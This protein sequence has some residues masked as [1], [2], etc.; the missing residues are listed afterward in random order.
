MLQM[1]RA[2]GTQPAVLRSYE[3]AEQLADRK[4]E[5]A[6]AMNF[7]AQDNREPTEEQEA[8][9]ELLRTNI[10]GVHVCIASI[11]KDAGLSGLAPALRMPVLA[12]A[13]MTNSIVLHAVSECGV[14][15]TVLHVRRAENSRGASWYSFIR[16]RAGDG[17]MRWG[18]GARRLSCRGWCAPPLFCGAV[19]AAVDRA[20]R[21][22]AFEYWVHPPAWKFD[23][24]DDEWP[25]LET[26]KKSNFVCLEQVHV[27]W[28]N[29]A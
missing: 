8:R 5:Q 3:R 13:V 15:G 27:D 9:A 2:E 1:L 28:H 16:Y 22:R 29:M 20:P 12:S 23:A 11:A 18:H 21:L 6:S 26:V 17:S 24:A 7:A 25:R 4:A 14:K 10:R 19:H